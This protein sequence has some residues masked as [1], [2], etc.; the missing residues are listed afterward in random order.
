MSYLSMV[1]CDFQ[2]E[3]EPPDTHLR[4]GTFSMKLADL[5][6][7]VLGRAQCP[8]TA[9][10]C[11]LPVKPPFFLS[12][13][14]FSGKTRSDGE[15]AI[16]HGSDTLSRFRRA[17]PWRFLKMFLLQSLL[18]ERWQNWTPCSGCGVP[19]SPRS[20][21]HTANAGNAPPSPPPPSLS[22]Q[23]VDH[24]ETGSS[25]FF[26]FF[27]LLKEGPCLPQFSPQSYHAL[28]IMQP[29]SCTLGSSSLFFFESQCQWPTCS[30]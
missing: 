15:D 27:L 1:A 26:P 19:Q 5:I 6:P 13:S 8:R 9:E 22:P 12:F 10:K 18:R 14:R 2:S 7:R 29:G 11:A 4:L 24:P 23:T 17:F 25:L 20:R 30:L 3:S 21:L 28:Q 16:V